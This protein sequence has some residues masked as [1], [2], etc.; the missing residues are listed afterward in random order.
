MFAEPTAINRIFYDLRVLHGVDYV[1]TSGAARGRYEADTA[2]FAAQ[3]GFYRFLDRKAE[4]VASFRP[5]HGV[6]GPD[7]D[8]YR[9]GEHAR[10]EIVRQGP[11]QALWWA[12]SV[13]PAF[14]SEYEEL[15]VEPARRSGGAVMP[16]G[17]VA[18]WVLGLGEFF[19][20][21]VRP[22]TMLLG[23]ELASFER[24]GSAAP[25]LEAVHVMHPDDV[26]ACLA[27]ARCVAALERWPEVEVSV[28]ST[29]ATATGESA[30]RAEL[31]YL[32]GLARAGLGRADDARSDFESARVGATPGSD[33]QAAADHEARRLGARKPAQRLP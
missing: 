25:L 30:G 7:V 14:R 13:P 22:F 24:Y 10:D 28:S 29:L 12:E 31:H 15:V 5:G 11:L 6:S 21:N 17:A 18:P 32:R 20:Q 3:A 33:L 9:I 26:E 8:I 19:D 2:R 27:Y 16:N 23:W 4:H 1:V